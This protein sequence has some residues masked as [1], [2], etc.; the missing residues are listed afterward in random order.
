MGELIQAG[1]NV[2]DGFVITNTLAHELDSNAIAMEPRLQSAWSSIK[3]KQVAV[4][5]S[6]VAEDG[7]NASFAGVYDSVLKVTKDTLVSN[8][9]TVSKSLH[10]GLNSEY[11]RKQ[12]FDSADVG[13]GVLVQKM[14]DADY[15]GVLLS[16]IH[17]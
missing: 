12:S 14:V 9:V 13:G 8:V 1:Y 6:G 17:I 10:T 15:A 16:L 4:R 5:S 2:P 11:A 3:A 7:D